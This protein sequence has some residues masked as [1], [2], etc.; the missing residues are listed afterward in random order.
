VF[1]CS[2]AFHADCLVVE[3]TKNLPPR[4]LRRILV[5]QDQISRSTN[6]QTPALP[7]SYAAAVAAVSGAT[8][9]AADTVTS[10]VSLLGLDK[11]RELVLPD[12]IVGAISASVSVGVASGRKALAPL[13]P[14]ADPTA[15]LRAKSAHTIKITDEN[16][17]TVDGISTARL[18]EGEEHLAELREELDSL[19]ASACLLCDGSSQAINRPFITDPKELDDWEL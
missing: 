3:T 2:H 17:T 9:A 10:G 7:P 1:P 18:R 4:T 16:S 6:R 5:L 14:F 12:A 15:S 19:V 13:D 11:L 8:K